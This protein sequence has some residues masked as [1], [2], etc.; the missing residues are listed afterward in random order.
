VA[1]YAAQTDVDVS[2]SRAELERTLIRYG[3]D[4]FA[5]GW[6]GSRAQVQFRSGGRYVRFRLPIPARSEFEQTET[7]K[8]RTSEQAVVK[9]WEQAQRQRWRALNLV[10][11]AK[12][13]AVEAGITDFDSEFLAHIVLPDGT[14]VAETAVPAIE[15]AY[16][17]GKMPALLPGGES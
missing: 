8:A 7:G 4:G 16:A 15:Q 6:E 13:E 5:Y 2:T 10:V 14:T 12:L 1:R 9:A 3:A 17:T 11:K